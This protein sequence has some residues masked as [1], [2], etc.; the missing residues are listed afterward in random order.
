MR[1]KTHIV[2]PVFCRFFGEGE[3]VVVDEELIAAIPGFKIARFANVDIKPSIAI[4]ISKGYACAPHARRFQS[5]FIGNVFEFK[6]ALVQVEP[7][8]LLVSTK[9][10]IGQA[11]IINVTDAY[12]T[13]VVKIPI[14]V[15]I[16]SI[17]VHN[18]VGEVNS[19]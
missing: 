2:E 5:G 15:N 7:V 14:G 1:R 10:E 12:A 4:H 16:E 17:V 18:I 8:G 3:I 19:S 13:A 9:K 6:V 11:I